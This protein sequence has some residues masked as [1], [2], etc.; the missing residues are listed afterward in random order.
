MK[1]LVLAVIAVVFLAGAAKAQPTSGD[2]LASKVWADLQKN[3]DMHLLDNLTAVSLYDANTKEW[4]GGGATSVY[5][6]R[7]VHLGLG[8][9]KSLEEGQQGIPFASA[10]LSLSDMIPEDKQPKSELMVWVNKMTL[11][12]FAMR[13]W[14]TGSW[15]YGALTGITFT[16]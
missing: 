8:A 9:V 1:K 6:Y 4:L 3:S 5:N 11:G 2:N 13:D 16:W 15:R 10:W 7:F 12:G 14:H